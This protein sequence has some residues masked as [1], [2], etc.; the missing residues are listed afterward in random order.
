MDNSS[1]QI[2]KPPDAAGLGNT[3][4]GYLYPYQIS[5]GTMRGTQDVGGEG[6]QIDSANN[7][8]QINDKSGNILTFGIQ[9]D[10][11]FG[12]TF[13][14]ST[15]YVLRKITFD[16][17]NFQDKKNNVNVMRSG[18]MPDGTYGIVT[19]KTGVNV[20]DLFK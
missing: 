8:I 10:G 20:A 14:D 5:S 16:Q 9:K 4:A 7:R 17:D 18:A 1:H 15:G 2:V 3:N 19:A 6:V 13:S 11:T 12:I